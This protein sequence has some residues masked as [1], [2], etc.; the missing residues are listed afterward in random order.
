[1]K[2][3]RDTQQQ[4][5]TN[6]SILLGSHSNKEGNDKMFQNFQKLVELCCYFK[7]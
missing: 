3:Q 7:C 1:M 5:P 4:V 2:I 6:D